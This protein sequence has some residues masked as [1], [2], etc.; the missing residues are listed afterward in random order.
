MCTEHGNGAAFF[1]LEKSLRNLT[2]GTWKRAEWNVENIEKRWNWSPSHPGAGRELW[3]QRENPAPFGN[4][5]LMVEKD[6]IL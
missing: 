2:Q 5:E 3:T 6:K 1:F 4:T